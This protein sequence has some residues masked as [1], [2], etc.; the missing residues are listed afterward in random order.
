MTYLDFNEVFD[1][2]LYKLLMNNIKKHDVDRATIK[3]ICSCS[4]SQRR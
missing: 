3:W 4:Y 1:I 2:V